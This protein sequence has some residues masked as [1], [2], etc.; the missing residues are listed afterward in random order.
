MQRSSLVRSP[1]RK[2][3]GIWV[4]FGGQEADDFRLSSEIVSTFS[5]TKSSLRLREG[6]STLTRGISYKILAAAFAYILA[7]TACSSDMPAARPLGGEAMTSVSPTTIGS[8]GRSNGKGSSWQVVS[9][10][11]DPPD[12]AD[13]Y[14]DQLNG[15]SGSSSSDVWAV[16][17]VCCTPH[18]SQEYYSSLIEH[19]DGASWTIIPGASA[20][21]ADVQLFAVAA[22]SPS[23]AWAFGHGGYPDSQVLIEH[24]DGSTWS[25]VANPGGYDHA[26]LVAVSAVS[27]NDIWAAGD[28]N[29]QPL[30]EHWDGSQWTSV[31]NVTKKGGAAY[32]NGIAASSA[33]DIM[34]VGAYSSPNAHVL[35]ERWNGSTWTDVSPA[36]HFFVSRFLS[37]TSDAPGSYWAAGWEDPKK[38]SAVPQTLVER[39]KGSQFVPVRTPNDE[40]ASGSTLTNQLTSIVAE[41]PTNVW[42]VGLWTYF[43]G[44]GT[45]RS[46]FER[47]N[48]KAWRIEP[49][50]PSLETS[51]NSATNELLSV[52]KVNAKT[53]WAVGN[54]DI[55]PNCCEQ[56]LTVQA[57][58]G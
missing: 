15:V 16:G 28:G 25:V 10:P 11:N 54:Q 44:V 14:D 30:V 12:S 58:H 49:G 4:A 29:F 13:L 33:S 19:W 45:P 50:P 6:E 48:G 47:W 56:T 21:P 57:T 24:W 46:L 23:D 53:L 37:V 7:A 39:W 20:E 2:H 42:A 1:Q 31:P 18:G 40:P 26:E 51:N 9:S 5:I 8:L 27:S 43:P 22:I 38:S 32:L 41:S 3:C 17:R 35:A 55:P 36:K 52:G 34:A